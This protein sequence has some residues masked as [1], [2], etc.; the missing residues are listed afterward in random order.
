MDA[1]Q[2][3]AGTSCD[4][5][6]SQIATSAVSH[7]DQRPSRG[8]ALGAATGATQFRLPRCGAAFAGAGQLFRLRRH[9]AFD[10]LEADLALVFRS[11]LVLQEHD[12]DVTAA[13][14]L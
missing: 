13:L 3:K 4:T 9:R 7:L 11:R 5:P 8:R 10:E 12:A 14:A 2:Q 1:A 6:A